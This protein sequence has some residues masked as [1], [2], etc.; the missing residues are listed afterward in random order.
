MASKKQVID[1]E[2]DAPQEGCRPEGLNAPDEFEEDEHMAAVPTTPGAKRH[3]EEQTTL[4]KVPQGAPTAD[5]VQQQ[6]LTA[7][8]STQA[9]TKDTNTLLNRLT[10]Q[11]MAHDRTLEDIEQKLSAMQTGNASEYSNMTKPKDELQSA[12]AKNDEKMGDFQKKLDA[13]PAAAPQKTASSSSSSTCA[14][15]SEEAM[16]LGLFNKN[17]PRH[18]A[19]NSLRPMVGMMNDRIFHAEIKI[20]PTAPYLLGSCGHLR[21]PWDLA[22][23]VLQV[24]G[25][26]YYRNVSGVR[27]KV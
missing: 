6:F 21:F 20:T 10:D 17:T 5:E 26:D 2:P 9:T 15:S 13:R 16:I 4:T 3:M 25:R 12:T 24:R 19:E 18:V 11:V 22:H 8:L 14:A 23:R 7:V 27:T 1:V